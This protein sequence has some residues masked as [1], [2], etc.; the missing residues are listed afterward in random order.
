MSWA[1]KYLGL[2][3]A[4]LGRTGDLLDCWGLLARVYAQELGIDLPLYHGVHPCQTER[5][6]IDALITEGAARGP[7]VQVDDVGE[8]DALLFRR[9]EYALHVGVAVSPRQMLH[10]REGGAV[11]V[12]RQDAPWGNRFIAAYRHEAIQ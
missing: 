6:E 12:P 9:G 7:W 3:H 8:F 11:I 2:P 4:P 5:A 10:S 1:T